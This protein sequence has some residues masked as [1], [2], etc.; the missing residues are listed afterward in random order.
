MS[1]VE[2]LPEQ[3]VPVAVLLDAQKWQAA[4]CADCDAPDVPTMVVSHV[5]ANSG[6]GFEIR[7]CR[8]CVEQVLAEARVVRNRGR[9]VRLPPALASA[10]EGAVW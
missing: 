9:D 10:F 6:A 3:P 4:T 2:R 1:T 7:Y 8:P 5:E